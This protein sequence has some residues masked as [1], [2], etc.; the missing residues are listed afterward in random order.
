[1]PNHGD[2]DLSTKTIGRAMQLAAAVRDYDALAVQNLLQVP[3]TEIRAVAVTLA[4]MVNVDAT[5]TEL[6]AWNDE[7]ALNAGRERGLQPHGTHAAFNRHKS[8]GESPCAPCVHAERTYQR[9]RSRRRRMEI[10]EAS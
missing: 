6:L 10:G 7:P 8:A 9:I 1:M 4:A 5:P 2:N 3:A